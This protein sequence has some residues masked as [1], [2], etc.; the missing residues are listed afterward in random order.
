MTGARA[1]AAGRD[2]RSFAVLG[3]I[4]CVLAPGCYEA[5][6]RAPLDATADLDA[7]S[8][9]SVDAALRDAPDADAPLSFD[10]PDGPDA[11][12]PRDAP[13][14]LASDTSLADDAPALRTCSTDAGAIDA[15]FTPSPHTIDW[16]ENAFF[17]ERY[18]VAS[19]TPF[20]SPFNDYHLS[21]GT[22]WLGGAGWTNVGS[23][24]VSHVERDGSA[25]SFH[26]STA[27]V[28]YER[29]DYDGGE[30]SAHFRL[31]RVDALVLVAVE[32]STSG[33]LDAFVRIALDG[34][35]DGGGYR[36]ERFHTLSAPVCAVVPLRATFT[37]LD[38]AT[39]SERTFDGD[40]RYER[41]AVLD[42]RAPRP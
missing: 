18:L 26:L 7:R 36:D 16:I 13:M 11:L 29:I 24:R 33:T 2:A 32:G 15:G 42:F 23:M 41:T 35:E 28:L 9:A 25:L 21:D 14:V 37:L 34:P 27:E 3:V 20:L 38:G 12:P 31:E 8:D 4:L 19:G 39:F 5:Q 17:S 40:V 22:W 30:H 1:V 6:P 10:A